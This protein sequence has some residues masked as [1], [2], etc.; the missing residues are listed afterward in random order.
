MAGV[1]EQEHVGVGHALAVVEARGEAV[2]HL[3]HRM[4]GDLLHVQRVGAQDLLGPADDLLERGLAHLV[5]VVRRDLAEVHIH[6]EQVAALAGD[7]EDRAAGRVDRALGADVREVR[8]GQRVHDAPRVVRGVAG[9]GVADRLADA[10]ARAV[11]AH[12]VLGAHL[13]GRA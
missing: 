4:P 11:R 13:A 5:V 8:V 12:H 3:V 2:A 1:A 6:A 10:G 9:Q 7:Q